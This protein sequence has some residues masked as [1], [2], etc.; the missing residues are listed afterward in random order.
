MVGIAVQV[1][2]GM[3]YLGH[4]RIV[5]RD[6][7][8]RNCLLDKK[9]N[10]KISDFGL[11]RRIETG[12]QDFCQKL[13]EAIFLAAPISGMIVVCHTKEGLAVFMSFYRI[14]TAIKCIIIQNLM[15][16]V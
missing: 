8:A 1:A 16:T 6:L 15:F 4:H 9:G 12:S 13:G 3:L 5:H 2:D 10:V 7:A 11:S 14:C